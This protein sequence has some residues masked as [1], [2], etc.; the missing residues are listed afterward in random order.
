MRPHSGDTEK[1]DNQKKD[2]AKLG[3]NKKSSREVSAIRRE[4]SKRKRQKLDD[5]HSKAMLYVAG[6]TP[7]H[8]GLAIFDHWDGRELS[9]QG[10]FEEAKL[11]L[12]T[13]E[14]ER[15]WATWTSP[16]FNDYF[17]EPEHHLLKI[18]NLNS[19][20]LPSPPALTATHIDKLHDA[21]FFR[22]EDGLLR[23]NTP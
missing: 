18:I 22:W 1:F 6:R 8:L 10:E 23:L 13:D 21:R 19:P 12:K 2:H 5:I 15:K 20:T 14:A 4:S 3:Q 7:L 11:Y 17:A 9:M 16:T